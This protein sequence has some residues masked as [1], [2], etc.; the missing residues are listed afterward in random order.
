LDAATVPLP[1]IRGTPQQRDDGRPGREL[2]VIGG[3]WR[4]ETGEHGTYRGRRRATRPLALAAAAVLVGAA[5]VIAAP[6]MIGSPPPPAAYSPAWESEPGP[7]PTDGPDMFAASSGPAHPRQPT[8]APAPT[9]AALVRPGAVKASADDVA[10]LALEAE[11]GWWSGSATRDHT[12]CA[13]DV[14]IV[15]LIGDWTTT[16]PDNDGILAF[17]RPPPAGA[18]I[19]TVHYV[20]TEDPSRSAQI[21]FAGPHAVT[22]TETF[23]AAPCMTSRAFSVTIPEDTTSIEFSNPTGHA[24][25]IDKIVFTR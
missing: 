25:S 12:A 18:Y 6:M 10:P 7:A 16:A 24:P 1:I 2:L 3:E 13:P 15:R 4:G 14:Q 22:I 11:E 17:R 20:I 19:M 23:T 5:I 8:S 9:S 21:R